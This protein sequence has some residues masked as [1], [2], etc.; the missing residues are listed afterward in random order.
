MSESDPR[1]AMRAL[2]NLGVVRARL[3]HPGY[4][5]LVNVGYAVGTPFPQHESDPHPRRDFRLT[6]K[7]R[8]IARSLF[9]C[10]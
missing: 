2:H 9:P 4:A 3:D 1:A 10:A 6:D 8:M 5:A 7:G